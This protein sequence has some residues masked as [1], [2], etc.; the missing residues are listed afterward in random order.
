MRCSNIPLF[1]GLFFDTLVAP[2]AEETETSASPE[3]SRE[4]RISSGPVV[5][6]AR[7]DPKFPSD[8]PEIE[9]PRVYGAPLLFALARDSR[10]LFVYWNVDWSTI[11]EKT[12]PVDRQVHLR[13]HRSDGTEEAAV[14]VEPMVGS[15]N[16]T[17][18]NPEET[19]RIELGYY[20]PDEV[21]NSVAMSEETKM[22]PERAS[23]SVD[24]DVATIP[25]HL[26]FQR[27]IDA[28][29]ASNGDG[30]TEIVS[31]LQKRA[32][33]DE[34]RALL[35]PQ[36]WEILRAMNVPIEEMSA[37]HHAFFSADANAMRKRA[38]TVLGFGGT[39]PSRGFSESS[40]S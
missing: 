40:W 26:S 13:I 30:I 18:S 37:S 12:A 17:V 9:L 5:R 7:T 24:V 14:P 15:S 39:S 1:V 22:P 35:T 28:F 36:D 31:R 10:T 34:E 2:M 4:Y 29:R 20:Q 25:F 27:L 16:L 23:K 19:Y 8:L 21:W 38:E 33:T 11:F 32:V 3:R 6:F